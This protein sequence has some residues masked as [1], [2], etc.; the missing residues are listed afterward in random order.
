MHN[1]A[2]SIME[3]AVAGIA[4]AEGGYDLAYLERNVFGGGGSRGGSRGGRRRR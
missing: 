3:W 1:V 4:D 2:D